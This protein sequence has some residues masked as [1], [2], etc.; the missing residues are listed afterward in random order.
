MKMT[1]DPRPLLSSALDQTGSI[2]RGVAP[3]QRA[4]PTPCPDYDVT[5]MEAHLLG[6]LGRVA[7][8]GA[9]GAPFDV[10]SLVEGVDDVPAAWD[11]ARAALEKVWS[12]DAVLERTLQVPWGSVPGWAAALGY[13][14]EILTHG[15]DLAVATGQ[16]GRLDES[17]AEA[18]LEGIEQRVPAEPRGGHIPFGPVVAPRPGA[19]PYE[20][21]VA[22]LGRDPRAVPTSSSA[23]R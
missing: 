1:S 18:A 5:L 12:D 17:L 23:D 3:D 16:R 2:V 14:Q 13:A 6:V 21:L 4:L 8:V 20:R 22:W 11:S 7:H 19:T 10:P 15:W 9:G